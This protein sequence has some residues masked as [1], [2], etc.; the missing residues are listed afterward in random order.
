MLRGLIGL[1][2]PSLLGRIEAESRQ[3]M[4]QCPNCGYEVSVREYGGMRYRGFGTVYRL[5]RCHGCGKLRMLRV[6]KRDSE[7]AR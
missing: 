6:Y 3:W 2:S 7:A 1:L 5:G 4:M